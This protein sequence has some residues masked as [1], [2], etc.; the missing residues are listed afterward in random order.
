MKRRMV[1]MLDDRGTKRRWLAL[2]DEYQ[3]PTL[4]GVVVAICFIIA[5]DIIVLC[6]VK[7]IAIRFFLTH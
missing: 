3:R 7:Y 4:L 5:L 1:K 2:Y 6:G